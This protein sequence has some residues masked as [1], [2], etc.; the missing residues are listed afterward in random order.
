MKLKCCF[1]LACRGQCS[2]KFWFRNHFIKHVLVSLMVYS[3]GIIWIQFWNFQF[4]VLL[5]VLT[6]RSSLQILLN[7]KEWV[8]I[9][10]PK[11]KLLW[12]SF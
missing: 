1:L 6:Y 7:I 10:F 8:G 3:L 12:L 4:R 2:C 5:V 11:L 9:C